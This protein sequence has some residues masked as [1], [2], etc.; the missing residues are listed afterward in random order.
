MKGW[1]NIHMPPFSAHALHLICLNFSLGVESVHGVEDDTQY[2]H[3]T[4]GR[5]GVVFHW[6]TWQAVVGWIGSLVRWWK[7]GLWWRNRLWL[8]GEVGGGEKR[9]LGYI[10]FDIYN[11]GWIIKVRVNKGWQYFGVEVMILYYKSR[12]N[13]IPWV[14]ILINGKIDR[15]WWSY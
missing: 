13:A 4:S 5:E 3:W 12:W 15:M 10:K 2:S 1:R 8:A 9:N 7:K 6:W 14:S 11:I